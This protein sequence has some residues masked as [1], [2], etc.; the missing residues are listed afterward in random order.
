MPTSTPGSDTRP[1]LIFDLGMHWGLDTDFY[2]R[3]GFNV[4]AL[5]ANPDMCAKAGERFAKEI[6]D[7]LLT[8]ENRAFWSSGDDEISF[9]INPEKD[10]WSSVKKGWAEKGGHPSQEISVKTITLADLF[11][12]YGVPRYIKCDMEGVDDLFTEQL[13]AHP[14]HPD[15]V[16]VEAMSV[17]TIC[18][19][20]AAGYD[21]FQIVNQ[22]LHRTVRP[23][24]PAREGRFADAQFNG[25]MSGLFG[26][27]LPHDM[28]LDT[29]E[30]LERFQLFRKLQ[31]KDP[32][33][34]HGWIDFHATTQSCLEAD[35]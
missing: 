33:L 28:W 4:V 5:E 3:K 19:L 13:A 17:E 15:F 2:L 23:V 12:R 24:D 34:G 27:E 11:D 22:A 35:A 31:V 1:D 20:R 32:M 8:I 30:C 7:G 14:R 18:F 26:R 6:S 25:H 9:H 29:E 16:S 10:D 21:R